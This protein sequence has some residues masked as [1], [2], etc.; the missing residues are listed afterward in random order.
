VARYLGLLAV[1]ARRPEAAA[2]HFEQALSANAR[3]GIRSQLAHTKCDYARLLFSNGA[4]GRERAQTLLAEARETAER[5]GLVRLRERIARLKPPPLASGGGL[6]PKRK[7]ILRREG[8]EWTIGL[9]P[10]TSRLKDG[11][12]FAYLATLVREPGREFHVLDLA[13]GSGSVTDEGG[14]A[15]L[16]DA[17]DLST[18]EASAPIGAGWRTSMMS[19]RRRDASTTPVGYPARSK[20]V[21]SSPRSS[22]APWGWEAGAGERVQRAS[23]HGST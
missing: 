21:N 7:A 17:G 9:E 22:L 12:G 14:A 4:D 20:S 19:S 10:R 3:M 5:L 18:W 8:H 2:A 16:G 13:A 1:T 11:R 6:E 15:D 23:E